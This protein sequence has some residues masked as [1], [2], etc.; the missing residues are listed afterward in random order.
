M[1]ALSG[2]GGESGSET[3]AGVVVVVPPSEPVAVVVPTPT[4]SPTPEPAQSAEAAGAVAAL[5]P[6]AQY[7]YPAIATASIG[8]VNYPL[9]ATQVDIPVRLDHA[10]PNTVHVRVKTANGS[11]TNYVYSGA[12]FEAVDKYL[13]FRP[14]DPL[15]QTISVKIVKTK[16][17]GHFKVSFPEAPQ[18]ANAGVSS[19]IVTSKAGALATKPI[20][21]GFRLPR[22]FKAS[23]TLAY[24]LN[25]ATVRWSDKGGAGILSTS[26]THGRAQTG[27]AETGLYLD[28]TLH[29]SAEP[30]FAIKNGK[31]VIHSQKLATP[32]TYGGVS[33]KYG[34]A[35]LSGRNTPETQ[36][37]YGQYEWVATMPNRRGSWPALWLI[38]VRGWPPEIDVYE[39]F[40]QNSNWDFERDISANI[41]GGPINQRKFTRSMW[42]DATTAY[43]IGNIASATHRYAVDIQADYITW[44]VDGIETHQARNP[45]SEPFY[46]VMNVAVKTSSAFTDGS[47]DMAIASFKVWRNR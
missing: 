16:E 28:N 30:A 25:P 13:I 11:G 27:N 4:P 20:I 5:D 32:L 24:D 37:T 1:L 33:Y 9:G 41:H 42:I 10:T 31:L 36:V 17:G 2:C 15:V 14:G 46:P 22:T 12:Y 26:F 39:G 40:G 35:M 34:A 21:A 23:G 38:G 3:A 8:D 19:A 43:G 47:G 7:T 45:F 29:P 18:G 44:F 6:I